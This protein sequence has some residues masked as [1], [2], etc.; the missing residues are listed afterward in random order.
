M[1][2]LSSH[3]DFST[4]ERAHRLGA[5]EFVTKPF[6]PDDLG[7]KVEAVV[8]G[9]K[10]R[11]AGRLKLG[12]MLVASG[13]VTQAQLDDALSRQRNEGGRLGELLVS[14]DLLSEQDI[15][16]AV[17]SQMRI[18]VVD[19]GHAAPQTNAL[20]LLPRDFI[21]RHRV[22]PLSLDEQGA[23]TLAMTNPLDV[24]TIDEVGMRTKRRI[25]P[26]ICTESGFDDAVGAVL[27][28]ARQAQER[29]SG[30]G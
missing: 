26:V 25:V 23:L 29:A 12:A 6:S 18:G 9:R 27:H 11:S 20:G 14:E 28:G 19:L 22:I 4:F 16:N 10:A 7:A 1:V 21:I 5:A 13:L 30:G 8:S 3:G 24:I 15:V 2:A 17:A